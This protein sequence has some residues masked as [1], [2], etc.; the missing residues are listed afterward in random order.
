[1]RCGE[2]LFVSFFFDFRC[3]AGQGGGQGGDLVTSY[4][5]IRAYI[6]G[7][8]VGGFFFFFFLFFLRRRVRGGKRLFFVSLP[9]LAAARTFLL[10]ALLGFLYFILRL[11][12]FES[13]YPPPFLPPNMIVYVCEFFFPFLS[14]FFILIK[15]PKSKP[16]K[17]FQENSWFEG[18]NKWGSYILNFILHNV[19]IYCILYTNFQTLLINM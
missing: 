7:F 13:L 3:R 10:L 1:M 6:R 2:R 4:V 18:M 5:R 11:F 9:P 8:F 14:F 12:L 15:K 16:K 19:T 17:I